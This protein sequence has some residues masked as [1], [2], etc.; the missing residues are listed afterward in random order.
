MKA[1][2]S[3]NKCIKMYIL[4]DQVIFVKSCCFGLGALTTQS[5]PFRY[6]TPT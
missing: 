4:L 1:G 2:V 6:I 5:L 3:L